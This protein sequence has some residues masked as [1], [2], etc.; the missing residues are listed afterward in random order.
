M[1]VII[2]FTKD[3]KQDVKMAEE[4]GLIKDI[5]WRELPYLTNDT[6]LR[7]LYFNMSLKSIIADA[8]EYQQDIRDALNGFDNE[9]LYNIL[10]HDYIIE[11]YYDVNNEIKEICDKILREQKEK[12]K[13]LHKD[14]IKKDLKIKQ[15]KLLTELEHIE[16]MLKN[17]K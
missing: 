12:L 15:R 11:K 14:E 7:T 5:I 16:E 6:I 2:G 1:K 8:L 13:D 10:L 3:R 4:I 17:I 9:M